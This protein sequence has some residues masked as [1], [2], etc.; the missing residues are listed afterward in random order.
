MTSAWIPNGDM[1]TVTEVIQWQD[2]SPIVFRL[3]SGLYCYIESAEKNA[4]SMVLGLYMS[5]NK[6]AVHCHD[7]EENKGGIMAH[8]MH[9]MI[10]VK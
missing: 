10:A 2:N 1:V 9:R 3:S 5:G 7:A 6:V 4:Y 8:K